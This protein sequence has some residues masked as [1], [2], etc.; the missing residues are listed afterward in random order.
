MSAPYPLPVSVCHLDS[1]KLALAGDSAWVYR[2][3]T[4]C[5][6]RSLRDSLV[7][8]ALTAMAH[9]CSP[10][11]AGFTLIMTVAGCST[12]TCCGDRADKGASSP[13]MCFPSEALQPV[14]VATSLRLPPYKP[15]KKIWPNHP[16]T[17][18]SPKDVLVNCVL[19]STAPVVTPKCH[20]PLVLA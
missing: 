15:P 16:P 9:Q 13:M 8:K 10:C 18:I 17:Q 19:D 20:K 2:R 3:S 11:R 7:P 4:L 14:T 5:P 6:W 12:R 1:S